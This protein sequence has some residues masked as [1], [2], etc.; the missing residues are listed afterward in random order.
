MCEGRRDMSIYRSSAGQRHVRQWCEQRIAAWGH[1]HATRTI[2]T[3]LGSTHV[4][5]SGSGPDLVLLAGTNFS[6]ATWLELIAALS[7]SHTVHAVDLPGQ[8]GLSAPQRPTSAT[9]RYG[10][11]LAEI[12]HALGG[13][14]ATLVGHSLGAGVAMSGIAAGAPA[15]RLVLLDPAGLMR[16]RVSVAV[17]RPTL[18]WLRRPDGQS[19]ARLLRMMMAPDATPDAHLVTWMIMVGRHVRTSLAPP[20]MRSDMLAALDA[21]QVSILSGRH[22]A[23]LPPAR[24]DRAVTRRLGHATFEVV[25]GAGHLLPHER[26]DLVVD[27][28][29]GGADPPPGG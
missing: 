5:T 27:H 1:P 22:D 24:L 8:P 10:E 7:S 28:V 3:S 16:L 29:R 20:P 9:R 6:T 19:S 12:L 21:V 2:P 13:S 15:A 11:W 4:L 17:L 18:P 25:D 14:P 26:P 23:F